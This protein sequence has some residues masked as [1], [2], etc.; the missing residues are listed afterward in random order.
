MKNPQGIQIIGTQRSG[1]N[2][3]RVILDQSEAIASPHP[4]HILVTFVPLLKFY[5]PLDDYAYKI[6]INDVADYVEANPV[7]WDGVRI[8]KD[9]IFENSRVHS[10]YEINR[11]IYEQAAIAKGAKY[12]CCKSM[13]NVHYADDLESYN[14]GLKYIYLYRDGRDVAVSFKKAI[15]GEK[16][17]YHLA[18]QWAYDQAACI[19]L[20]ERIGEERFFALNYETL[21]T[22]PEMLIRKLCKFLE[23]DYDDN[24]LSFYNSNESKATAA[25]GEMWQNLEKPIMNNNKGKFHKELTPAEIEIFELVSYDVLQKLNYPVFT[26]LTNTQFI[27][28]DAIEAYG[29]DNEMLKKQT[30]N[31]AR[32]SDLDRRELQLQIVRDIKSKVLENTVL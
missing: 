10:I 22:Q 25:A 7:P 29:S 8:N 32:Q 9:W 1:S 3:L 30:L 28:P 4:P 24:M 21:I 23:I 2:L 31:N 15:V 16:H 26:S 19:K 17:I 13:A 11:L 12:W 18:Q 14:P 20:A 5:G 6:L 27:S